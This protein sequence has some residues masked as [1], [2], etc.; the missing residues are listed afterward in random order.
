MVYYIGISGWDNK[1]IRMPEGAQEDILRVV[2]Q[3]EPQL[4]GGT[5]AVV[6]GE[7]ITVKKVGE[8]RDLADVHYYQDKTT[9]NYDVSGNVN[10]PYP[11]PGENLYKQLKDDYDNSPARW[12]VSYW[13]NGQR[14]FTITDGRSN[15]SIVRQPNWYWQSTGSETNVT[16]TPIGAAAAVGGTYGTGRYVVVPTGYRADTAQRYGPRD[17]EYP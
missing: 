6:N 11:D 14:E 5:S 17:A 8:Y 15:I 3:G 7:T 9:Y 2:S 4:I 1:Y 13:N 16:D 10:E 12:N